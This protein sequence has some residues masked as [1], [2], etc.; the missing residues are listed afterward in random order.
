MKRIGIV[1]ARKYTN[2]RKGLPPIEGASHRMVLTGFTDGNTRGYAYPEGTQNAR[3]IY[4]PPDCTTII[5]V[6]GTAT[7]VGGSNST[8]V[9]GL[10]EGFAYYTAFKNMSAS[11]SQLGTTGGTAEFSLKESGAIQTCTLYIT[12][13]DGGELKFGLDDTQTDTKRV[14]S[15]SVDIDVQ[16]IY[17]IG[18]PYDENWALYQNGE[19]IQF[20]NYKLMIWN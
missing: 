19:N 8:Y 5:R 12:T 3:K 2:K 20:Q 4:L 7:V 6:K 9:V 1:G 17:S 13:G 15:L 11:V 10:T 14:W 18:L 16:Q